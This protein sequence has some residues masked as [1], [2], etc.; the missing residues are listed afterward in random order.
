MVR[1]QLLTGCRPGE[2]CSLRPCD[3]NRDGDIWEFIPE[4][5][6]TEHHCRSQ[7]IF[8]GPK[9]Q[10]ILN[11][12]I[13][14]RPADSFCFSPAESKEWYLAQ[15]RAN[16]QTPMTPSQM[17]RKRKDAPDK[18]PGDRFTTMAFGKSIKAACE[19]TMPSILRNL[20]RL[21]AEI[22]LRAKELRNRWRSRHVWSPNQLRHTRATMLRRD[23]GIE[24]AQVVL[25]HSDASL[26]AQVYA[27]RDFN[28]ARSIMAEVG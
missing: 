16:R 7:R 14:N 12:Y 18:Q 11:R 1:I 5:H 17:S 23:Y 28:A 9:A 20:S 22:R 27:E 10:G 2:I 4:S 19:K 15:R 21:P 6:K 13:D 3:V 24:S 25:G 8:I 26:T